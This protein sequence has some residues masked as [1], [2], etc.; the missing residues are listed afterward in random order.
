[1]GS[2]LGFEPEQGLRAF[3]QYHCQLRP[4][5][6]LNPGTLWLVGVSLRVELV[7]LQLSAQLELSRELLGRSELYHLHS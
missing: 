7:S 1:M 5:L 3:P 4:L 6:L 2:R